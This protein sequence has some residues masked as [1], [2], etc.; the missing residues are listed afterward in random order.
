M[1]VEKTYST[2]RSTERSLIAEKSFSEKKE[3]AIA[4]SN[5]CIAQYKK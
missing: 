5:S 1:E 3:E 2:D 4:I